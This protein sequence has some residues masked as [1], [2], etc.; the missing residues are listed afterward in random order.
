VKFF[1]LQNNQLTGSIPSELGN[2]NNV[3]DFYIYNNQL[4][5]CYSSALSKFC[6]F[7][8]NSDVSNGN[9]FD[10]PWNDFC[11][12]QA[13]TGI[14]I[15]LK[16][17]LEGAYD[18]TRSEMITNLNTERGLLPGQTPTSSLVAPTPAGQPYNAAPWNYTGTEG[19]DW[20]DDSY[21]SDAVDWVLISLRT[22][23]TKESERARAAGVINKD[24]TV[25]LP[26]R[27]ALSVDNDS[28][29]VVIEH[30]NHIGI[31]T[32]HPVAISDS[33]TYDFT[34]G[35]SYDGNATGAGQKELSFGLW[36]M[37]VGDADQSADANSY[38][39]NG[40]DKTPW[41]EDNGSFYNYA[42]TD[43]NMDGDV[44]GADKTIWFE[45]YGIS[46]A[47]FER[48]PVSLLR[49]ASLFQLR[50]NSVKI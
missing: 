8:S 42:P 2:L 14:P 49:G 20:T 4:S 10:A 30:R 12:R 11:N 47:G 43:F 9:N 15:N 28:V 26:D 38:D 29:Y 44:S 21:S 13:G 33:L 45:N 16:V 5:G 25:T 18:S 1:Y 48:Y 40:S 39:I 31:M 46:W 36:G 23:I 37:Y 50:D 32:P 24:G 6:N 34:Q 27:C 19:T 41:V 35:N 22:D 17:L 7:N 3:L